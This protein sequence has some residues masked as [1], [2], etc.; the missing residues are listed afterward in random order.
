MGTRNTNCP[1]DSLKA[2]FAASSDQVLS[3]MLGYIP[4]VEPKSLRCKLDR[5]LDAGFS[6]HQYQVHV[7]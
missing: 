4:T 3:Q 5:S 1:E 7:N 2:E 6:I